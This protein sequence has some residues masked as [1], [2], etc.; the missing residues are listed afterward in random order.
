M[1]TGPA[2]H[3]SISPTV[4]FTDS[5]A[6]RDFFFHVFLFFLSQYPFNVEEKK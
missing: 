2:P 1:L 4:F 6:K 3:A 5:G